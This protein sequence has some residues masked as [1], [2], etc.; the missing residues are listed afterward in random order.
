MSKK[1]TEEEFN[2]KIKHLG[3]KVE[4]EFEGMH[5]PCKFT[6]LQCGNIKNILYA[7]NIRFIHKCPNCIQHHCLN[8]NNIFVLKRGNHR[9]FCYNCLPKH[10]NSVYNK[11]YRNYIKQSVI[12]KYGNTC[13]ICGYNTCYLSLDFHHLNK[14]DKL[15]QPSKLLLINK[16]I[17]EIFKELDKCILICANCHRELHAKEREE[18]ERIK[19]DEKISDYIL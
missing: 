10:N 16:P 12:N 15:F 17:E 3:W 18:Q 19:T 5:K 14:D 9:R 11:L 7:Y 6:C 4:G 13:V 2:E 1:Y 8:C